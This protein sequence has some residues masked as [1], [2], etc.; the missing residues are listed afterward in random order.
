MLAVIVFRRFCTN[1]SPGDRT[2]SVKPVSKKKK[3]PKKSKKPKKIRK[4]RKKRIKATGGA[5][6][7]VES[8]SRKGDALSPVQGASQTDFH[9]PW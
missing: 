2:S 4:E 3:I 1:Y 8:L 7:H 6:P 9:N 5:T